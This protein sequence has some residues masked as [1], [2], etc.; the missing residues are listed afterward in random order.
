MNA[1]CSARELKERAKSLGFDAVG[2]SRADKLPLERKRLEHW[3]EAGFH[4]GMAYMGR[5]V[6]KREDPALL[7][8]N[9]RSVV[10]TLTNYYT[11]NKQPEGAPRIARYAY[12]KDYHTVIR[13][14]LYALKQHL[15]GRCFVDSAPV[16]EHAW[17][18]RSGLGWIG[19]NT[20]LIN[21]KLGSF[22]FIGIL[23]TTA[24][25]DTYDEPY[26]V[27]HCGNCNRCVEACPTGA[28]SAYALD[29]RK[30]ISYL[31]IEQREDYAEAIKEKAGGRI[32]GCDICQEVCPWNREIAEHHVEDFM[33]LEVLTRF[34][35]E[36]WVQMD[37]KAFNVYFGES[38]LKRAGLEKLHR[39][40]SGVRKKE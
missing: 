13:D 22:C 12:G 14:R 33:P 38:P 17:A 37:E 16:F 4:G 31:T 6:E 24:V 11:E 28:L 39:N 35:R 36:D 23:M 40:M 8:D 15:E 25:F 34:N 32:F 10:V 21:K 9:V 3:L 27:A 20:L 19:K 5:N 26:A 1:I 18:V 7:V 2:I 30:C 29:A